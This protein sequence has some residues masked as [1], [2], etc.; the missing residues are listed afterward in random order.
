VTLTAQQP[1]NN[2][3]R[4]A[5]QAMAAA[6]GGTQSLHTNSMDE[7][8]AL[9][10]EASVQTALRTQQILAYETGVPNVT[11]P[12]GGS[13][14]LE[15]LTDQLEAEAEGI[16]AEIEKIGGVVRGIE[17]GWFQRQ[18]ANSAARHQHEV[19]QKRHVVVGVNEF[20]VD[21][22]GL[23]IPLLKIGAELE[24]EQ[25]ARMKKLRG[26]RDNDEVKR[27]LAVLAEAARTNVNV[28]PAMLDCARAYATLFEIRESMEQV[29][30]SY[31][32]PVFF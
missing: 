31:R 2:V 26:R 1:M 25:C 16:F 27:R 10:T 23:Q 8:L 22:E 6:L 21:E 12:L 9:P 7:T 5:Y 28:I 24:E 11:D 3:V 30:G 13:Y 4:V 29:Y 20:Q 18:I 17:M 14:Y 32:E 19:E 15:A